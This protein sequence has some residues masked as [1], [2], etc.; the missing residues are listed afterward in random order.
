[1]KPCA[2]RPRSGSRAS[3]SRRT[4]ST[5]RCTPWRGSRADSPGDP[6]R[7]RVP[8]GEHLHGDGPAQR[9]RRVLEQLEPGEDLAGFASYNLGIALLQDGRSAG[10]DRATGRGR[11]TR[12]AGPSR[13][14]DPRQVQPGARHAPVRIGRLRAGSAVAGPRPPRGTVL[15]PGAAA[16]RLGRGLRRPHRPRARSVEHPGGTRADRRRGPGSHARRPARVR[17]PEPARARRG[18]VRARARVLQQADRAGGRLDRQHP[19]RTVSRRA[20][21]RGDPAGQGLGHPPAHL[22]GRAGD[23]LPDGADGVARLPDRAAELPRPRGPALEA[24]RLA[25]RLRR[26]RRRHPTARRELRAA[27]AGGRRPVPRAGRA[28]ARAARAAPTPGQSPA[29]T[30]DRTAARAAGDRGREDRRASALPRCGSSSRRTEARPLRHCCPAWRAC[31]ARS[32]GS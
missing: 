11:A 4:S 9:G 31:R 29:G 10:S 3:T 19:G 18:S 1:M 23:L 22:A 27:A 26:L 13:A 12:R 32:P 15:E 7:R 14:G 16:C 8:A 25:D 20:D 6:G 21:P 5:T 30:A 2:T 17:Q 28:D 24:H